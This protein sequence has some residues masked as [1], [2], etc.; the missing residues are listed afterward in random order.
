MV[1]FFCPCLSWFVLRHPSGGKAILFKQSPSYSDEITRP[2]NKSWRRQAEHREPA[3]MRK[4][5]YLKRHNW[6]KVQISAPLLCTTLLRSCTIA[7]QPTL[8][9]R[10][11]CREKSNRPRWG[12]QRKEGFG[13]GADVI[14]LLHKHAANAFA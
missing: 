1:G 11:W 7:R 5:N 10:Y 14:A 12:R 9:G 6:C 13:I 4:T 8:P 2:Y 3:A